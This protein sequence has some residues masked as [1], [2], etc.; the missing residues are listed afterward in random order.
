MNM[1]VVIQEAIRQSRKTKYIF[2]LGSVV[3]NRDRILGAGYNRVFSRSGI[4]NQGDCAE[5]LAIKKTPSKLL[6]GATILTCRVN[7]SGRLGM[8]KPCRR[9]KKLII[10]SNI[11]RIIYSTPDG[12][13]TINL[14]KI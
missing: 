9:C 13:E 1:D 5:I 3:F 8:A 14:D 6:R 2:K 4:G 12:W 7:K 11:S 10:K